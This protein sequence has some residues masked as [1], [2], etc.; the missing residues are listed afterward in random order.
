MIGRQLT[1][2]EC[3]HHIDFNKSNNKPENLII[4]S[5]NNDHQKYHGGGELI[6]NGD[7]TY[8]C[9]LKANKC[10]ICGKE[11][12]PVHNQ[13]YCSRECHYQSK[14]KEVI[15]KEELE[16]LLKDSSFE[17]VAR[18]FNVSSNAVR[19]WCKKLGLPTKASYYKEEKVIKKRI[20]K[21]LSNEQKQEV[22]RLYKSGASQLKL[23]EMFNV[24]RWQIRSTLKEY[25]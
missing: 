13:K 10:L 9:K 20:V 24:T 23:A 11:F 8:K 7:G 5:T 17:A 22:I 16:Q 6:P 14:S 15:A 1:D 25:E 3:V 19:K 18:Q 2:E 21:T 12:H 4:F